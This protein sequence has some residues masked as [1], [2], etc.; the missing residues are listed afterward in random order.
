[1]FAGGAL[2]IIVALTAIV[3]SLASGFAEYGKK[4]I[5][6]A[7]L[8]STI[9]ALIVFSTTYLVND[10]DSF[11]LFWILAF[12]F[13]VFGCIHYVLMHKKFNYYDPK[14]KYKT[15]A[16]EILFS[17]AVMLF[18][19]VLFSLLVYFIKDSHFLFYPL[20]LSVILF[21]VP[22]FFN[23]TFLAAISIPSAM[24]GVWEYPIGQ[25]IDP[26]PENPAEKVFDI[27]FEVPKKATDTKKT[28]F[29][30][31][32][33]ENMKL[34]ELFYHFIN[35]YNSQ[36]NETP[37]EITNK[38]NEVTGWWFRSK[39]KWYQSHKVFNPSDSIKY[40]GITKNS[41]VI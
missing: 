6:I 39:N 12:S 13:L 14:D 31:L 24:F 41:V 7:A 40:N 28:Y 25:T 4:P 22:L 37:I 30:A 17:F 5:V 18:I 10:D 8:T 35:D 32:A 1:M 38:N 27:V 9:G 21:L 23:H 36:Q 11:A 26:P 16:A 19:I 20:L 3:K 34:G 15:L 29:R 2:A 33:P